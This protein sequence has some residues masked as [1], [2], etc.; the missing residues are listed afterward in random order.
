MKHLFQ[1]LSCVCIVACMASCAMVSGKVSGKGSTQT[2]QKKLTP[3]AFNSVCNYSEWDVSFVQADS[4]FVLLRGDADI[5]SDIDVSLKGTTLTISKKKYAV[6]TDF[7]GDVKIVV[8]SPELKYVGVS[9]TGDFDCKGVLYAENLG[10]DLSG[11]GDADFSDI[12]CNKMTLKNS[13]TGDFE[14]KRIKALSFSAN[15]VGTG[16]VEAVLQGTDDTSLLLYGTGDIT[17]G[18]ID[19]VKASCDLSGTGDITLSGSLQ[20]LMKSVTGTGD[21][22]TGKLRMR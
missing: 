20:Q 17:I 19:C 1:L 7:D 22:D 9:G 12:E 10:V 4:S 5:I 8:S 11:T 15:S 3:G 18:F 2:V 14:A 16:D 6:F 13:G 21:L